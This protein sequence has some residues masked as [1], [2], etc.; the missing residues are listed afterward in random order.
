MHLYYVALGLL[1]VWRITHLLQ[2][3]DGP[4]RIFVHL[5][6]AAGDGFW[7]DL[8]DCFYC[9]SL[10][11]SAPFAVLIG[12]VW[13]E[14]ALLWLAL[15]AAAILLDRVT[16]RRPEPIRAAWFEHSTEDTP[17]RAGKKITKEE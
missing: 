1:C 11:I 8:L 13:I 9:L 16:D 15:S 7:G 17:A 6:R 2:A 4:G 12:Q 3:E 10:W 14:R 5:R